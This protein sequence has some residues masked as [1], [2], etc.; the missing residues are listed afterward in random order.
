MIVPCVEPAQLTNT[1]T[2]DIQGKRNALA[3]L[4]SELTAM[5]AQHDKERSDAVAHVATAQALVDE[6]VPDKP[7]AR[8]RSSTAGFA[9]SSAAA[10]QMRTALA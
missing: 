8:V 5:T 4:Q 7:A 3:L 1:S 6:Q 10:R 2:T 9:V